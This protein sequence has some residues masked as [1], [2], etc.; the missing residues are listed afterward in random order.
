M[1]LPIIPI[2]PSLILL[3]PLIFCAWFLGIVGR[4]Y[5]FGFWGNFLISLLFTP[6]VGVIVILA[7]DRRPNS[8]Q[9]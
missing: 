5:K 7:Q 8:K 1:I 6:I 2:T 3:V 4:N 9:K